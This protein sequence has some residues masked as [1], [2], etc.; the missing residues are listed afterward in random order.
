MALFVPF[1]FICVNRF[2]TDLYKG[3]MGAH[4]EPMCLLDKEEILN[5]TVD[6]L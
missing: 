3:W 1:I 2:I 5:I 6:F 4:Y